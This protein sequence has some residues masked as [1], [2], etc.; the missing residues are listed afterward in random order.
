MSKLVAATEEDIRISLFEKH[1]AEVLLGED[2]GIPAAFMLFYPVYST[3]LGKA[4]LFLE[5]LYVREKYRGKGY[6]REM[7]R[8]LAQVAFA[9]GAGRL[10]WYVLDD[11]TKGAAFYRHLGANVLLDRHTY[12]LDGDKLIQLAK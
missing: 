6:G 5:D 7:F 10:D 3:F 4:N 2:N 11:N 12:R 8:K 1:Q 9:Y